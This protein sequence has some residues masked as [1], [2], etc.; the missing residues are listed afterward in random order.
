MST[1]PAGGAPPKIVQL[2]GKAQD[3]A[4]VDVLKPLQTLARGLHLLGDPDEKVTTRKGTPASLQEIQSGALAISKNWSAISGAIVA[5]VALLG[6]SEAIW[7]W[8]S[9]KSATL[10][11]ALVVSLGFVVGVALLAIAIMVKADVTARSVAAAARHH[12]RSEVARAFLTAVAQD[13]RAAG[14]AATGD[15]GA[16]ELAQRVVE[17]I[18]GGRHTSVT[19]STDPGMAYTM[20]RVRSGASG[21]QVGF[22]DAAGS[23]K[24]FLAADVTSYL[25]T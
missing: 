5:G 18:A 22:V 24:W 6:G 25:A 23:E 17:S 14:P 11:A 8:V 21:T 3:A 13:A 16:A 19:L 4:G 9:V 20:T 10:Q 12:G 1:T 2:P 15:H 7:N